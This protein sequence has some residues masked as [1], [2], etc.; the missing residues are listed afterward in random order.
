MGC[1]VETPKTRRRRKGLSTARPYGELS[2]AA[3]ARARDDWR[4]KGWTWDQW[5]FEQLTEF[6][7]QELE[8][9]WGIDEAE[10]SWSLGYCQGDGVS[11][12][13]SLNLDK[14]AAKN[15]TIR[16]IIRTVELLEAVGGW[17]W[18]P[19]WSA[20][21]DAN[22]G[23][24]DCHT[25]HRANEDAERVLG[26]L[27]VAMEAELDQVHKQACRGLEKLGNAEIEYRDSDE[28][29]DGELTANDHYLFTEE[30]EFDS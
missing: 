17:E 22:G 5:D 6:F 24:A 27:C 16:E 20:S 10:V 4:E 28:Y 26:E 30:G 14:M 8:E 1:V 25:Y 3:K 2:E 11:F 15:E 29:L 23:H 19:E 18:S 13:A 21:L 9:E 12:T 7:K